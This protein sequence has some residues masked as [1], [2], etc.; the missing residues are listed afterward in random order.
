M[1]QGGLLR[2]L[3]VGIRHGHP[4][5]GEGIATIIVIMAVFFMYFAIM[6][7]IFTVLCHSYTQKSVGTQFEKRGLSTGFEEI[8]KPIC[9]SPF[10]FKLFKSKVYEP[11]QFRSDQWQES[12]HR[13]NHGKHV[14]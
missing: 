12:R 14:Q 2:G 10:H 5:D 6:A 13:S 9:S 4:Q 11:Y 1:A 8:N 3:R 7:A